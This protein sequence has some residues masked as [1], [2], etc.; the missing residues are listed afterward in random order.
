MLVM[1][2]IVVM[3]M[4]VDLLGILIFFSLLNL[5]AKVNNRVIVENERNRL[6]FS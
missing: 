1:M 5:T 2:M 6:F 3:V 4:V